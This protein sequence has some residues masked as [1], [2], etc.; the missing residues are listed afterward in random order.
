MAELC[1]IKRVPEIYHHVEL[2]SRAADI[3]L[4][5]KRHGP[6]KSKAADEK[7]RFIAIFKNRF[8]SELDYEYPSL[9]KPLDAKMIDQFITGKLAPRHIDSHFYLEWFFDVYLS[10]RQYL[11]P[12]EISTSLTAKAWNAF[13]F[14]NKEILKEKKEEFM[15]RSEAM[16]LINRAR[17]IIRSTKDDAIQQ[18]V[19][20]IL[21]KYRKR[22]IM[23]IEFRNEILKLEK[24]IRQ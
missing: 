7:R 5:E 22:S 10:E 16:D 14:D 11:M 8:R 2:L 13:L 19:Y 23:F 15:Q 3:H 9:M 18:K 12:P 20:D 1:G 6:V 4:F 24:A 17:V 21:K